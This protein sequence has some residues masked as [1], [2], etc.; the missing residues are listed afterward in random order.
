MRDDGITNK[1]QWL[2]RKICRLESLARRVRIYNTTSVRK[3]G[4][5]IAKPL[6]SSCDDVFQL[7]F[8]ASILLECEMRNPKTRETGKERIMHAES[9][10]GEL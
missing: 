9:E 7:C 1:Y 4:N 6:L 2:T 3:G 5:R 8:L 10:G